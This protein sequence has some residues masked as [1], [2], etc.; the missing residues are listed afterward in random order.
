MKTQKLVL[1]MAIS[2]FS[3]TATIA[4]MHDH[5]KMKTDDAAKM[6]MDDKTTYACPMKCEGDKTYEKEGKC[7]KCAMN[8]TKNEAGQKSDSKKKSCCAAA[9][10]KEHKCD[11][12]MGKEDEKT[13]S[14][15]SCPMK[16]EGDKTYTKAGDC[17]KCGMNLKTTKKEED[18]S[19]HNH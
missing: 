5:S 1:A 9:G 3:Y 8:L 16:C 6:K 11:M 15:Y 17:P 19:G 13:S 18:H 4:Q 14:S 2:L 10:G 7:P 12:K